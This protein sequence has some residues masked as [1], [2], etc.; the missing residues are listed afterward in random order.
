MK[1]AMKSHATGRCVPLRAVTFDVGGT[2]VAPHPSV[3]GIYA[4]VLTEHGIRADADVIERD[5][6]AAFRRHEKSLSTAAGEFWERVFRDACSSA[7]IPSD[8]FSAVF[9]ATYATFG[10]GYRWRVLEGARETV[11][12][13]RDRGLQ[14]AILSNSDSRFHSVL[15]ELGLTPFFTHR[16]LSGEVGYEKPD[17]RLFRHVEAE[18]KLSPEQILHVG[19][20]RRADFEGART[21]GWRAFLV[22]PPK[23]G[24]RTLLRHI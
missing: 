2:L 3:G 18:L 6:R 10:R 12:A 20:S 17:V 22:E 23:T 4:E 8:L 15:A 16:F 5:F 7:S 24:I 11:S 21:A 13:L 9:A 1:A 14:L 19:D